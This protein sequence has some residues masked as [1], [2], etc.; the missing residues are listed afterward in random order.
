MCPW[1]W[2]RSPVWSWFLGFRLSCMSVVG[3]EHPT[4]CVYV[5]T[6]G[7]RART[8]AAS[9]C[10]C[11]WQ[12]AGTLAIALCSIYIR[13]MSSC[14]FYTFFF[15]SFWF[16]SLFFRP[17]AIRIFIFLFHP[18]IAPSSLLQRKH[19]FTHTIGLSLIVTYR[20]LCAL[21]TNLRTPAV[22]LYYTSCFC[23]GPSSLPLYTGW[24]V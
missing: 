13:R 14:I 5:W 15:S 1:R 20:Y 3:R 6:V 23:R 4:R 17:H 18:S 2:L 22:F 16:V 12:A 9:A 11:V 24:Y 21:P 19:S 7:G 10:C 8:C